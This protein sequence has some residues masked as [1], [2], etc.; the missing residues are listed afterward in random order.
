[1]IPCGAFQRITIQKNM[2]DSRSRPYLLLHIPAVFASESGRYRNGP[3]A[4]CTEAPF[5][6][7]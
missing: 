7:A 2:D 6:L 1:M 5:G 4:S 3:S